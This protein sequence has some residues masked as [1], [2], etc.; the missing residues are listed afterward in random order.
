M[1]KIV[2]ICFVLIGV[3]F[4]QPEV[5]KDVQSFIK[6]YLNDSVS[7]GSF[8]RIKKFVIGLDTSIHRSDL[9]VSIPIR[10]Y[11]MFMDSI[12]NF[13]KNIPLKSL[14]RPL[15]SWWVGIRAHGKYIYVM[16]IRKNNGIVREGEIIG[17]VSDVWT[18]IL[19]LLPDTLKKP[20]ILI[21]NGG[22]LFLHFAQ[23]DNFN[24]LYL[25][26]GYQSDSL[27]LIESESHDELKKNRRFLQH[28]KMRISDHGSGA[29]YLKGGNE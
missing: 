4:G 11:L 27:A 15:S 28:L 10:H 22:D 18:Q 25:K 3:V 17:G 1:Q 16:E 24:L 9:E 12:Q 5:P 13:E 29:P 14:I 20:P 8:E 2:L 23:K 21:Q 19:A 7:S 6:N 26:P